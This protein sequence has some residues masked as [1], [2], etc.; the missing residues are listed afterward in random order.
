M[1]SAFGE[2]HLSIVL[3]PLLKP[4][5]FQ[6]GGQ[7]SLE[8]FPAYL[9]GRRAF[10]EAKAL[11]CLPAGSLCSWK[12]GSG[13]QSKKFRASHDTHCTCTQ[14]AILNQRNPKETSWLHTRTKQFA[15]LVLQAC[16][17][18]LFFGCYSMPLLACNTQLVTAGNM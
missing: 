9:P 13:S 5:W 12:R 8:I 15:K 18:Q 1:S 10:M 6:E 2:P 17:K 14:S 7:S 16:L 11:D 3:S 4:R